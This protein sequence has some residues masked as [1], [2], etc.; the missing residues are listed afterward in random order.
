MDLEAL[1]RKAFAKTTG[2][3]DRRWSDGWDSAVRELQPELTR[4]REI[5][6]RYKTYESAYGEYADGKFLGEAPPVVS[7]TEEPT[8]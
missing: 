5:E 1:R 2:D 6:K 3:A 4:L 8:Q 7:P